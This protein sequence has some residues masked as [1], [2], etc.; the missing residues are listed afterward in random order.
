MALVFFDFSGIPYTAVLK[1]QFRS[2]Q[3]IKIRVG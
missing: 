3:L 1:V 2:A